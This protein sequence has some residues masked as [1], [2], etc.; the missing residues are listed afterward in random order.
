MVP[1]LDTDTMRYSLTELQL[2]I[3]SALWEKGEATVLDV[4][5]AV[6]R[7]RRIAQS[8]VATLLSRLEDKGV[9]ERREDG[10]QY[11]YRA[12]VSEAQVR[13]SVVSEF[14]DMTERLFSGDVAGLVSELLSVRDVDPDDLARAREIIERKE[15]ELGEERRQ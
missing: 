13:H 6:R 1:A 14:T 9:V 2:A 15:R 4:H 5:D 10:R 12:T 3:M 7:E 11:R 8:T